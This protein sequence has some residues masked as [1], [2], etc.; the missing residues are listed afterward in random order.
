MCPFL[1]LFL[2]YLLLIIRTKIFLF[3]KLFLEISIV[4]ILQ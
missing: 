3:G 1:L 2:F 4:D